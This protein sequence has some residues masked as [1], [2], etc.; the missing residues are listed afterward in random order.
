MYRIYKQGY[1]TKVVS[2]NK[3]DQGSVHVLNEQ[4]GLTKLLQDQHEYYLKRVEEIEL[5]KRELQ[6]LQDEIATS[7]KPTVITEGKTDKMILETAW[8]KLY[9]ER[10]MPFNITSCDLEDGTSGGG[11]AGCGILRKQ[12]ESVRHDSPNI[13]IGLFDYDQAGMDAF[14]L[15]KNYTLTEG[16]SNIK[17]NKNG[18]GFA[19]LLPIPEGREDFE[20][21]KN[22]PI[23]FYF[24]E[25]DLRKEV[26]GYSLGLIQPVLQ[27]KFM[28]VIVKQFETNELQYAQVESNTK[29]VFAEKIVPTFE[30]S[31]FR[32]FDMLFSIFDKII[33]DQV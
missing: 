27:A 16:Y 15:D 11:A 19:V 2:L 5:Q 6:I 25:A 17:R 31:S 1:Q 24:E 32:N 20:T 21:T 14:K 23:E 33:N 10:E 8:S 30:P 4:L 22:L 9:P 7:R 29:T 26:D 18:R 12:L 28:G 13:I 3:S